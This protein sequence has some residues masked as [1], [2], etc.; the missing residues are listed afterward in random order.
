MTQQDMS[1]SGTHFVFD[2]MAVRYDRCNHLFSLGIDHYWRRKLVK[3]ARAH[4]HQH[5]LDVC[6]GTGDIVYSFLK[7]SPVRHIVGIDLSES[8]IHLAMEKQILY[9]SKGWMYNKQLEWKVAD[10][11]DAGLESDHFDIVSCAFGIRNVCQR[12]ASLD[13]MYRV[14]KLNGKLYFLEFSLPANPLLRLMYRF[15]LDRFMPLMGKWIVGDRKP[16]EYLA[17]SIRRWH[18]EVDFAKELDQ[19][20]FRL[21]YKTPLTGGIVTMWTAVKVAK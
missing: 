15:Y 3:T 21:L 13:E 18:T 20:G 5:V 11:A 9:S 19:A 14:L 12:Q 16:L 1:Q 6:S 10:A 4:A 2:P 7:H 8:M 17:Q